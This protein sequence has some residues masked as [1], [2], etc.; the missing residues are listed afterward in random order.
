[1]KTAVF[2]LVL[3]LSIAPTRADERLWCLDE[4]SAGYGF[5]R[6]RAVFDDKSKPQA[7]M[8]DHTALRLTEQNA[9]L[10]FQG[11]GEKEFS[12]SAVND[13][14]IQ[15][16]RPFQLFVFDKKLYRFNLAE[17]GGYVADDPRSIVLRF[18]TCV[19]PSR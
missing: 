8:R 6:N 11:L 5:D 17:L 3:L 12:C 4:G 13:D 19:P 10:N 14:V 9:Y 15:C 1:M 7:F 16:V 2:I 18:G